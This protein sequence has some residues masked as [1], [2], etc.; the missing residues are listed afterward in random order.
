MNKLNININKHILAA[1]VLIIETNKTRDN[2]IAGESLSEGT[3]QFRRILLV[4][5]RARG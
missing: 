2:F 4:E 3:H 5:L 1:E